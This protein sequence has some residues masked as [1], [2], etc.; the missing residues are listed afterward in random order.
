MFPNLVHRMGPG[1]CLPF[2]S[3]EGTAHNQLPSKGLQAK[4][5]HN[6]VGTTHNQSPILTIYYLFQ[7][8]VGKQVFPPVPLPSAAWDWRCPWFYGWRHFCPVFTVLFGYV[9]GFMPSLCPGVTNILKHQQL[10][11]MAIPTCTSSMGLT[12]LTKFT[13]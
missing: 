2:F 4:R 12:D 5:Q 11:T 1:N 9:H 7:Y 3:F 13:P 10:F 6:L 8:S